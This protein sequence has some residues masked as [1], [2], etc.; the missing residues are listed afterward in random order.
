[1]GR[2]VFYVPRFDCKRR[3][4][5]G[6]DSASS[7]FS[8]ADLYSEQRYGHRFLFEHLE[9][10]RFLRTGDVFCGRNDHGT[11]RES[12]IRKQWWRFHDDFGERKF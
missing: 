12:N 2:R 3:N 7:D 9:R 8:Y 1:C 6:Y 5:C 4:L 10:F 11:F